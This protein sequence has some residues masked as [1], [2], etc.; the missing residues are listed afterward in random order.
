MKKPKIPK[1]WYLLLEGARI[2]KG[3]KSL[4]LE[5]KLGLIGIAFVGD[6]VKEGET[7]IRQ[8]IK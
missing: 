3:D 5:N 8:L 1:G 7:V 2:K 6:Y 4:C